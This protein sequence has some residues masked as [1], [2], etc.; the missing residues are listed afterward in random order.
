MSTAAGGGL[1]KA[2]LLAK[3]IYEAMVCTFGGLAVAIV[4]TL[5]YYLFLARIER[6]VSEMNEAVGEFAER[7]LPAAPVS[8]G[9]ATI[10]GAAASLADEDMEPAGARR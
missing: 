2:E 9:P 1:G 7:Y 6:L 8:V 4:C 5:F 10:A 3:G